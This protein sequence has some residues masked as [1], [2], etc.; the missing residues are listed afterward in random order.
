MLDIRYD[1]VRIKPAA[2]GFATTAGAWYTRG[3]E[4]EVPFCVSRQPAAEPKNEIQAGETGAAAQAAAQHYIRNVKLARIFRTGVRRICVFFGSV[5]SLAAQTEYDSLPQP[6]RRAAS[7]TRKEI[8][9][10]I[11][12]LSFERGTDR[13]PEIRRLREA[14]FCVWALGG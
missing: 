6:L 1:I 9:G 14:V 8:P 3:N 11:A 7:E 10:G 2:G 5:L 12:F 13:L 4:T